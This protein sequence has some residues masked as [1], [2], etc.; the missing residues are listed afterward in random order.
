MTQC[1]AYHQHVPPTL[2]LGA[3]PSYS[4]NDAFGAFWQAASLRFAREASGM[5]HIVFDVSDS[6]PS[7]CPTEF[8][9]SV[10][11]PN[12]NLNRVT[13]LDVMVSTNSNNPGERCDSGSFLV[14]RS[15]VE[16]LISG[17]P[18]FVYQCR[19]D[20]YELLLVRCSSKPESNEACKLLLQNRF[21]SSSDVPSLQPLQQH[22]CTGS[23]ISK[24]TSTFLMIGIGIGTFVLGF[25]L[26]AMVPILKTH[27]SS[28]FG[29]GTHS[30][31]SSHLPDIRR[32]AA[33]QQQQQQQE[34]T[35]LLAPNEEEV[36]EGYLDVA[37]LP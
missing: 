18:N 1:T 9:G 21:S 22:M 10:E 20:P 5:A 26:A 34:G 11:L 7:F 16:S 15:L 31:S 36:E 24:Q 12:L 37:V 13:G 3:T 30:S 25:L 33:Q 29:D 19:N 14:L 17:I 28:C 35:S 4:F 27:I 23:C 32:T 8:F 2:L 6:G